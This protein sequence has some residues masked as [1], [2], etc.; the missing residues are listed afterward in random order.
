VRKTIKFSTFNVEWMVHFFQRGTDAWRKGPASGLGSKPKDPQAC[1]ARIAGVIRRLDAD[2]VGIC[3]GPPKRSQLQLFVNTFLD[4]EYE[5]YSAEDG[6]QSVHALVR[7]RLKK[8]LKVSQLPLSDAVYKQLAKPRFFHA[9]GE[10]KDATR[11][12]FTRK[13]VVLRLEHGGTVTEVMTLHTKSKFSRLKSPEDWVTRRSAAVKDA[14]L[15][16]QKLSIEM[17]TIRKYIAHG[18]HS[19]RCDGV[20]VMGDLNDGMVR[21]TIDGSYL[22]HS[23]VHELRGAFHHEVALMRHVFSM[24]QFDRPAQAWTVEFRDAT[25]P[26]KK[27]RVLLDH[28]LFSPRVHEGG[29]ITFVPNSGRVEHEAFAAH[30]RTPI[31]TRDDRPSDHRPVSALFRLT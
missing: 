4:G 31:R 23:I 27:T 26:G 5:V 2:I 19:R 8:K 15:A 9:F 12:R 28:I 13:P 14:I 18:L 3:E 17:D 25:R 20:I 10:V 29:K 7:R 1:A 11:A 24:Q 6:A 30:A 16:R 21:D 22:L